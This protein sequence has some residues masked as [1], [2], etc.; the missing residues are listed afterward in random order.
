MRSVSLRSQ[1]G[2]RWGS[3]CD[4]PGGVL[5]VSMSVRSVTQTAAVVGARSASIA[6]K[7]LK[8]YA[9]GSEGQV[10]SPFFLDSRFAIPNRSA[11]AAAGPGC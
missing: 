1:G 9:R 10:C 4:S 5:E 3:A 7:A 6:L 11:D 8:R 2:A